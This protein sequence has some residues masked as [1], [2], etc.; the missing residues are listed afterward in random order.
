MQLAKKYL[1]TFKKEISTPG[2]RAVV[3]LFFI[4]LHDGKHFF[5][6]FIILDATRRLYFYRITR[7]SKN[8][9]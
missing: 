8:L 5:N 9:L 4:F 3:Q 7:V 1:N 2:K 6:I